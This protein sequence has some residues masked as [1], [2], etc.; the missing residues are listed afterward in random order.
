M[1]MHRSVSL[2]PLYRPLSQ[3][4]PGLYGLHGERVSQYG[5]LESQQLV[6]K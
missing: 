5:C 1:I 6:A 3:T 4:D 2:R